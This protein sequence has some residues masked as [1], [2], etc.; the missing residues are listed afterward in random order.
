MIG[1]PCRGKG[2]GGL[3]LGLFPMRGKR[4]PKLGVDGHWACRLERGCMLLLPLFLPQ[5]SLP[6]LPLPN[7]WILPHLPLPGLCLLPPPLPHLPLS[8]LPPSLPLSLWD[9]P[10][11]QLSPHPLLLPSLCLLP[12]SKLRHHNRGWSVCLPL[13]CQGLPS[14]STHAL[15]LAS[16]PTCASLGRNLLLGCVGCLW[17]A[18][19][20]MSHVPCLGYGL[21]RSG[22]GRR[23]KA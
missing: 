22:W 16:S 18:W 23:G 11:L 13:K 19:A 15:W 12:L 20:L 5:L 9:L 4:L 2:A 10:L 6:H 14:R 7:P 3:G 21:V 17:L 1:P 8:I